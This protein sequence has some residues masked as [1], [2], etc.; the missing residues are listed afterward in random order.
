M[1]K[2]KFIKVL[3]YDNNCCDSVCI[4]NE[5]CIERFEMTN[6]YE[7]E[8]CGATLFLKNGTQIF[9]QEEGIETLQE[10]LL[11]KTI[12]RKKIA[13]E[14]NIN[15]AFSI[16][17]YLD[18]NQN[19]N[20]SIGIGNRIKILQELTNKYKEEIAKRIKLMSYKEFLNTP[21]WKA[22]SVYM[23]IIKKK[24]ELCGNDFDLHTHHKTYEHHGY[25]L[26]H[27]NDLQVVC[28]LC[29]SEIHKEKK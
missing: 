1:A 10:E 26:L 27:L 9:V 3:S 21:Y 20:K 18:C 25:E 24:C 23:K 14:K 16:N 11:G 4:I 17:N 19:W 13:T 5:D 28:G 15:E 29:H 12:K 8:Y 7:E 2:N 6:F 22:I